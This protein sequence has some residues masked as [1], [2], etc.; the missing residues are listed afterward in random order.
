MHLRLL[1]TSRAQRRT[2]ARWSTDRPPVRT[3]S[4][5]VYGIDPA[6]KA[7][8]LFAEDCGPL[9]SELATGKAQ[10]KDAPKVCPVT[11]HAYPN[12]RFEQYVL[13]F[14][15]GE[16]ATHDEPGA[17]AFLKAFAAAWRKMTEVGYG[18]VQQGQLQCTQCPPDLCAACAADVLC[19]DGFVYPPID[20][21]AIDKSICIGR[22]CVKT[23]TALI[24]AVSFVVAAALFG[25]GV[26]CR[27]NSKRRL[28][29]E[30]KPSAKFEPAAIHAAPP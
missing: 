28:A 7:S 15:E 5:Q 24:A 20:L 14:A 6:K 23:S 16:T 22:V 12:L 18:D 10:K 30:P 9:E 25:L 4:S 2:N 3:P 27:N 1:V 21:D 13:E 8:Q 17:S 26:F 11:G 29:N 19:G